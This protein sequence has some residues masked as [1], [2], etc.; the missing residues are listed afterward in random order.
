MSNA[1]RVWKVLTGL[2]TILCCA[3]MIRYPN[4]G[5]YFVV[6]ILDVT[7]LLYGLRL[8][9]YYFSLARYMVGGIMT[10]YKSIVVLDFGLFI[11][12]LSSIPQKYVMLYLIITFIFYGATD[13]I[14]A[15]G[16][17]KL[18]DGSWK[19]QMFYGLGKVVIGVV[20]VFYLDDMR[21]VTLLYCIGLL[22]S[23]IS[24]IVSAFRKTA[25]VY[26]E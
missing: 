14:D 24:D 5:F 26:I 20:C 4:E 21:G 2:F 10:L 22:H 17:R 23:A 25:I 16:A 7:L 13:I 19:Y 3:L 12:G 8:L 15:A 11:F 6:L 18:G 1:K 9:S